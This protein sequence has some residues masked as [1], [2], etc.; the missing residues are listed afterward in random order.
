MFIL[1]GSSLSFP[2]HDHKKIVAT[3]EGCVCLYV[4]LEHNDHTSLQRQ[5]SNFYHAILNPG[6]VVIKAQQKRN[7]KTP[8]RPQVACLFTFFAFFDLL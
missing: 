8:D 6:V 4:L 5:L 1:L 3:G 2:F 7:S